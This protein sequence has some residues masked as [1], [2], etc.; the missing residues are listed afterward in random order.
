MRAQVGQLNR[1]YLDLLATPG[2]TAESGGSQLPGEIVDRL[3][4]LP[5]VARDRIAA[6]H[7][8]LFNMRFADT[9]FW[10]ELPPASVAESTT[11]H[12]A[13]DRNRPFVVVALFFA[14]HVAQ[15]SELAARLLLAMPQSTHRVFAGLPLGQL[16]R[17]AA[18]C[19]SLLA[20][21]WPQNACFWPDLTAF[22]ADE[23]RPEFDAALMLGMQLVMTEVE[24][25]GV[26]TASWNAG[27]G[28][29]RTRRR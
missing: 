16:H 19:P 23:D 6:S 28:S 21:R 14:W 10:S 26:T 20:P 2:A 9:A 25:G 8:T 5:D 17:Y 4:G 13:A 12:Y 11:E 22:A 15:F 7:V 29:R 18:N 3:V 24:P 27:T 1:A